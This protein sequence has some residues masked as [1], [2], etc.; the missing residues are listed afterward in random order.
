MMSVLYNYTKADGSITNSPY[1]YGANGQQIASNQYQGRA[2]GTDPTKVT[3]AT[4]QG[5]GDFFGGDAGPVVRDPVYGASAGRYQLGGAQPMPK[6][7]MNG[8]GAQLGGSNATYGPN[9]YLQDQA[10]GIQN[11]VN[12][13]LSQN[14]MPGIRSAAQGNGQYGSSRQGIAEGV[15]AGNASGQLGSAL[16]GLYG[17]AYNTDQAN[18]TAR[19][20]LSNNYNL[21]LGG[22]GNQATAQNQNFYTQQR[23]QDLQQYGLGSSLFGS[24]VNGQLGLGQGMYDT[25]NT[26]YQ[27]PLGALQQYSNTLTPYTGLNSSQQ[28]SIQG[29]GG[30]LNGAV[31]GALAGARLG[32]NLGFGSSGGNYGQAAFSQTGAG[33]SGFGTGLAYGNQDYGAFI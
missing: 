2:D 3:Y 14:I 5:A 1:E 32:Q 16:A 23:G 20:G 19:I 24:G 10:N 8:G 31:G 15:A 22:L 21:G 30:G 7:G 28:Q 6:P 13:N 33:S 4:P 17:G 26:A 11:Q 9:P 27:A 18:Q 29:G 12:Q 25:G